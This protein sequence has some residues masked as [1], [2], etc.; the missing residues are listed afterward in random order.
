M[1]LNFW[2]NSFR[3]WC[4]GNKKGKSWSSCY[5][6]VSFKK[7]KYFLKRIIFQMIYKEIQVQ[8][9]LV[10][11]QFQ[12]VIQLVL[13]PNSSRENVYL[14]E[15]LNNSDFKKRYKLPIALVKIFQVYQL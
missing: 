12:E 6:N 9:R 2:K 10:S 4:N 8:S 13:L 3:F 1:I 7:K 15:I 11:L 5:Q 14:S